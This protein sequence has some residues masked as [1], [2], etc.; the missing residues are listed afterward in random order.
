MS[1]VYTKNKNTE[2]LCLINQAS[3]KGK[4][5]AW[6]CNYMKIWWD[7]KMQAKY[8][9]T[10]TWILKKNQRFVKF[11]LF[12]HFIAT[13]KF[14]LLGI[15][16][17]FKMAENSYPSSP[18]SIPCSLLTLFKLPDPGASIYVQSLLKFPT[19]GASPCPL[20]PPFRH[21]I[22]S[23]PVYKEVG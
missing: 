21:N 11:F 16:G 19:W 4:R 13:G 6:I 15:L 20:V 18:H 14:E 1:V 23:C 3:Q 5:I 17:T 9:F 12:L 10:S 22:D 7:F 2:L 8:L